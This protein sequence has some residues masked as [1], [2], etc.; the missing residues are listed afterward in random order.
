MVGK[1]SDVQIKSKSGQMFKSKSDS[2][3]KFKSKST[4]SKIV[5][6]KSGGFKSKFANP[7]LKI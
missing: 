5:K 6:S 3:K 2:L 4:P 7:D 1:S